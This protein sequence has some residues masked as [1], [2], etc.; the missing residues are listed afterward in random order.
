MNLGKADGQVTM[1]EKLC[2]FVLI[3]SDSIPNL[4]L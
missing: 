2:S 3:P 4:P 1:P